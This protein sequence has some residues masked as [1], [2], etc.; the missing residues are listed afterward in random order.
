MQ[1]SKAIIL[2]HTPQPERI[3]AAAARISTTPGTATDIYE[4]THRDNIGKLISNVIG[5][6]HK[7]VIE[8]AAFTIAFENVSAF[9]EQFLIEFRLAAY[10]IKSRRYVDFSHMGFYHPEFRFTQEISEAQKNEINTAFQH[11]IKALFDE[12]SMLEEKG[13]PREDARFVLPYCYRSNIYCT[14]NAREMVHIIYSALY[15][16]G[17]RFPELVN[18]GHQL[19]QQARHILP[20]VFEMVTRLESGEE[21]KECK[22]RALLSGRVPKAAPPEGLTELTAYTPSPE[23]Q[24]A[25]AALMA[26]TGGETDA[27]LQ[28]MEDEPDLM[29]RVIEIVRNDRRKRELEQ[30]H[31]TFRINGLSLA[32]LTHLARHRMQSLMVPSFTESGKSRTYL[33]PDSIAS[34]P[35]VQERYHAV[36]QRNL[37][38]FEQMENAG[39]VAEDLVYLYLSGNL[40]DV[41]TTMNARE[42]Y[43][44]LRLRTCNR[45]QWEIRRIAID[46]LKKLRQIAPGLFARVGPACFMDGQCPEGKLSCGKI[47]SVKAFFDE[48]AETWNP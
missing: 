4:K 12:Y 44:F 41:S 10:T 38:F 3:C 20:D 48:K 40:V 6:G 26:H 34:D 7:T 25:L 23:K 37:N 46:M 31:F 22:L 45:A 14:V 2:T 19:L 9:F 35:V 11:H 36:W 42:L 16:R 27:L 5:I 24:V 29:R 39:V 8:H 13:V 43:H 47:R 18:L 28:L 17:A 30:V 1:H 21:D 33:V 15:G 32:G